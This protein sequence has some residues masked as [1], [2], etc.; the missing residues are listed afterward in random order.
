MKNLPSR[1]WIDKECPDLKEAVTA[2]REEVLP[3]I[4]DFAEFKVY[5]V[6]GIRQLG[7]FVTGTADQPILAVSPSAHRRASDKYTVDL[8]T[9]MQTTLVHLL[10]LAVMEARGLPLNVHRAEAVAKYW[11]N[12]GNLP[13][14]VTEGKK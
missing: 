10:A 4:P 1:Y 12:T 9:A 6:K 2:V 7:K 11:Y 3:S 13:E 8:E 5:P 14:W